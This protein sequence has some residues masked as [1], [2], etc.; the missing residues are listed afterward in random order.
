MIIHRIES[1]NELIKVTMRVGKDMGIEVIGMTENKMIEMI[2]EIE[3]ENVMIMI[4]ICMTEKEIIE[5][6]MDG[7]IQGWGW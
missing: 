7:K 2:D 4:M 3:S 1:E 6:M 5:V